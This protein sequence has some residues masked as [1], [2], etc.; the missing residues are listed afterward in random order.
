MRS[1]SAAVGAVT[2][3]V[4]G[5]AVRL[6][7]AAAGGT[8]VEP[9]A[10]FLL[11]ADV[12]ALDRLDVRGAAYRDA[13]G[14]APRSALGILRDAGFDVLQLTVLV[15]PETGYLGTSRSAA[16][17]GRIQG[18]GFGLLL[19]L[20]AADAEDG[21]RAVE[22]PRR[23]ADRSDEELVKAVRSYAAG[24][25]RAFGEMGGRPDFLRVGEDLSH[26][27]LGER[28]R[29]GPDSSTAAW[30]RF[31]ALAGAMLEGA[32]SAAPG[33]RAVLPL[34][35]G[36]AA[37]CTSVVDSLAVRGVSFD[38]LGVV[39]LP[40]YRG[41]LPE[42]T[43]LLGALAARHPGRVLVLETAYPWTLRGFDG[44]MDEVGQPSQLHPGYPATPDGQAAWFADVI[45]AAREAG[46]AGVFWG[47]AVSIAARGVGS[48]R[49]NLALFD[50]RGRALPA[51][52]A[53]R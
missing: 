24:T 11:G 17:G 4:A 53:G 43:E 23:W 19:Q 41:T 25:V 47:D 32:R 36:D 50:E 3:L 28:G 8:P 52:T 12:T 42:L 39:W 45:A 18:A 46:A 14:G 7:A 33:V 22:I 44:T 15:D 48:S 30:D 27:F 21:P 49:E 2:A 35:R 51:L 6:A 34:A 40:W 26:G 5:L 20:R 13:D 16:M 29:V 38:L 9:P 37:W 1:A 31:A 10:E